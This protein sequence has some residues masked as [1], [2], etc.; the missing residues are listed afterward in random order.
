MRRGEQAVDD[1]GKGIRRG[2]CSK[3]GD[4]LGRR[5]QADQ[6]ERGATDQASADRRPHTSAGRPPASGR[7]EL[8]DRPVGLA[9]RVGRRLDGL[10]PLKRP[11]AR[12]T[13]SPA[14][15]AFSIPLPARRP[16]RRPT[17]RN[18]S[19]PLR[20]SAASGASSTRRRC[21]GSPVQ[22]ALVG[23]PGTIAGPR[24]PPFKSDSRESTLQ[25]ALG[26]LA[27]VARQ[28]IGGKHGAYGVIEKSRGRL[29]RTHRL[30]RKGTARSQMP[31]VD[32]SN[33]L[34]GPSPGAAGR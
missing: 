1:P 7:D 4:F 24:S 33:Q 20:A 15:P 21:S 18:R 10:D 8:I 26:L 22:Q 30:A 31:I 9:G 28:A 27:A 17:A 5:R 13:A 11:V 2:S 6:V 14:R 32:P 23:S 19:P 3:F 25:A 34:Q 12:L 29:I 16:P